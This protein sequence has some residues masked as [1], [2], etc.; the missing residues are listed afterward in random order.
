MTT[1]DAAVDLVFRARNLAGSAIA[2]LSGSIAGVGKAGTEAAGRFAGA[3]AGM[4]DKLANGIGMATETLASGGSVPEAMAQVGIFMA[5]QLAEQFGGQLLEKLASSSLLAALTAPLAAMGT[6]MGG[7]IAAAI[8]IGIAALPFILVGALVAAIAVLIVNPRH[9][10][11]GGRL[12]VRL[13]RHD[14]R[15][16]ARRARHPRR[17]DPEGVCGRLAAGPDRGRHVRRAAG[18]CLG[19]P[20]EKLVGIGG[21]ILR[22][23]I[24]GLAGFAGSLA[25]VII[26][27]FSSLHIDIGPFHISASGVRVDLPDIKV[28]GFAEGVRNYIGGLAV[29]GERGPE[30]VRLPRGADVIPNGQA[31]AAAAAAGGLSVRVEGV[32][33]A[34]L[35]DVVERGLYVRLRAAGTAY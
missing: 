4:G 15:P 16:A 22:T 11:E 5:G 30:L 2:D 1:A 9:P 26:D 10:R 31:G 28:P 8:P 6:A 12:C 23:I 3:F 29:V 13:G 32:T 24:G 34:G 17:R 25:H 35:V 7:L 18:D 14:R 20:A 33:A 19:R 27:A 21:D